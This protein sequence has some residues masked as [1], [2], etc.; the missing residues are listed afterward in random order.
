MLLHRHLQLVQLDSPRPVLV[1]R[2]EGAAHLADGI[3]VHGVADRQQRLLFQLADVMDF[4][5][6]GE[7]AVRQRR[8]VQVFSVGDPL[9]LEGVVGSDALL[10]VEREQLSDEVLGLLRHFHVL[11]PLVHAALYRL[12][13]RRVVVAVERRAPAQHRVDH[14]PDGPDVT[15]F[16]VPLVLA[17]A[18]HLRRD[19]VGRAEHVVHVLGPVEHLAEPKVDHL[20][21]AR[22]FVRGL[23]LQQKV[24]GLDVTVRNPARVQVVHGRQHLVHQGR[25]SLL[26]ERV[27]HALPVRPRLVAPLLDVRLHEEVEEV[28]AAAVLHHQVQLVVLRVRLVEAHDVGVVE[29]LH[30][31]HLVLEHIQLVGLNLEQVDGLDRHF[32]SR[33]LVPCLPHCCEPSL[34]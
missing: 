1:Q 11:G 12:V 33:F 19:V 29:H 21:L 5:E 22:T 4:A 16:A 34:S 14:H 2:A 27:L 25:H 17:R 6:R 8:V 3:A 23:G 31:L 28:A 9:M 10:R 7:E 30:H 20:D 13:D 24:L 15:R 32:L 26:S 18:K